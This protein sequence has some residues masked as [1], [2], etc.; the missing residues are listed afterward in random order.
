MR[1]KNDAVPS[2]ERFIYAALYLMPLYFLTSSVFLSA[3]DAGDLNVWSVIFDISIIIINIIGIFIC[4][5]SNKDGDDIEFI[6]R[7]ISISVVIWIKYFSIFVLSIIVFAYINQAYLP[8][9][10]FGMGMEEFGN[11]ELFMCLAQFG[12]FMFSF[13]RLNSLIWIASH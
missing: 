1:F 9:F 3:I 12:Y 10:D 4:Y 2:R 13:L 5:K 11:I 8:Q 7:Y 6:E